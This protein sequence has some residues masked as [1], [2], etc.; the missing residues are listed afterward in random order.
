MKWSAVLRVAIAT[1]LMLG[2]SG[3][4]VAGYDEGLVAYEGGQHLVGGN[5]EELA[6]LFQEANR[7]F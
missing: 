7:L 3:P 4:V 6:A 1:V 2:V 5:N